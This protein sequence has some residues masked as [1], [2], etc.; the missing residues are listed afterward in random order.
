MK[1]RYCYTFIFLGIGLFFGLPASARTLNVPSEY[2]TIRSAI[3]SSSDGDEIIVAPGTY[4]ENLE[5][6]KKIT[7]RSRDGKDVTSINGGEKDTVVFFANIDGSDGS[8]AKLSGFTITGGKSV[9]G[10]AGGITMYNADVIVEDNTIANNRSLMDGGGILLNQDST[11]TIRNNII[12][13]NQAYRFGGGLSIVGASKPL[14][15]NNIITNNDATG[16]HYDFWG[17]GGGALFVDQAS[18]PQIVKNTIQFN[19][20]DHAGG[21]ISLRKDTQ[22]I[23]LENI[24]SYNDASYG[25]GIHV[26]TEGSLSRIFENE[27]NN[28]TAWRKDQFSGS[29]YGGGLSIYDKSRVEIR[30]NSIYDNTAQSGGGGIVVS[31]N[32]NATLKMNKI[33]RNKTDITSFDHYSGGGLYVSNATVDAYNNI[34]YEN[35]ACIG[36]GIALDT[37]ANVQMRNNTIVKN[38]KSTNFSP[39]I[40]GGIN[41]REVAGSVSL[42]NNIISQNEGFQIFEDYKKATIQNNLI[43][44]DDVSG[45]GGMYY[46]YDSGAVH[47]VSVLNTSSF[48]NAD[49]NVSG[50]EGFQDEGN[51]DFSLAESSDAIDIGKTSVSLD[52]LGKFR[53][54]NTYYDAGAYEYTEEVNMRDPVYRFWSDAYN[55]HF[56]TISTDERNQIFENYSTPVWRF[57]G[58]SY[59]AIS[60]SQCGGEDKVYRFWSEVNRGHFFTISED[61]RDYVMANYPDNVWHYEGPAFCANKNSLTHMISLYRF[62]SDNYQGHFYTADGGEKVYVETNYPENIWR[63]EG[64]GFYV[65]PSE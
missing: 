21:G 47:E 33:F 41:I 32:A 23:I 5:I 4:F 57:E 3:S 60:L 15:Y 26:E 2:S 31:E 22:A 48:I 50:S 17:A 28:N 46:N 8:T 65:Y 37:N 6:R 27:I 11:A 12:D 51:N 10:R 7:L 42:I 14:I 45:S 53:P 59:N 16:A 49:S 56:Y 64:V 40:A 61:E 58:E 30:G 18:S 13:S 19:S 63:Y 24:I 62:W 44:D 36:G 39:Q 38:K 1:K 52:I 34:F 25:G 54:N 9:E 55:R 20:A 29:G 35:E 43:N